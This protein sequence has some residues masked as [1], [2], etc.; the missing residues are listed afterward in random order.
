[1]RAGPRWQAGYDGA[2]RGD[3]VS[4]ASPGSPPEAG[5]PAKGLAGR[6][7]PRRASRHNSPECGVVRQNPS[8]S[9]DLTTL[10]GAAYKDGAMPYS[11]LAQR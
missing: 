6:P 2:G 11:I 4:Y 3:H 8:Q 9:D 5:R 10:A 1:M 7:R